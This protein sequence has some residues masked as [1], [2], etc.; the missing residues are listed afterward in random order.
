LF[1]QTP[2]AALQTKPAAC[3]PSGG[4]VS[5]MPSHDSAMSQPPAE[6]R[7]GVPAV[8]GAAGQAGPLPSQVALLEQA[9]PLQPV[10][11]VA[12]PSAGQA[13]MLPMHFSATSHGPADGRHTVVDGRNLQAA[14]QQGPPSHCSPRS[15]EVSPSPHHTG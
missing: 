8:S 9:P 1:S 11:A 15:E 7:Q 3:T 10:P 14:L 4:Q 6:A 2:D 5:A 12:K 13:A